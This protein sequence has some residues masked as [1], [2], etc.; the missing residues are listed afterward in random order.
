MPQA[1]LKN[2]TY[3]ALLIADNNLLTIYEANGL[4]KN[5]FPRAFRFDKELSPQGTLPFPPIEY[6]ITDATEL[7]KNGRFW[8]VNYYSGSEKFHADNDPIVDQFGLGSTHSEYDH[9]ERLLEFQL[10]ESGINLSSAP[11]VQL[12]LPNDEPRKW[13]GIVRLDERGFPAG[14]RQVTKHDSGLCGSGQFLNYDDLTVTSLSFTPMHIV[15]RWLLAVEYWLLP[16]PP[17]H[18]QSPPGC[19]PDQESG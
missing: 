13:E 12:L 19:A 7:D 8:A 6:R 3:E 2:Q 16:L 9:L 5:D 1:D 17:A 15:N 11:P 14:N 4:G 10:T 18:K